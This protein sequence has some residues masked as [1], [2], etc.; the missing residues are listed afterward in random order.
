MDLNK[1]LNR[2]EIPVKYTWD[3]ESLYENQEKWDIDYKILEVE[4][5]GFKKF[6]GKLDDSKLLLEALTSRDNIYRIAGNLYS[7]ASLKLDEDTRASKYQMLSDKAF[8][9]YVGAD[10]AMAFFVPEILSLNL[11]K[12]ENLIKENEKLKLYEKLLKEILRKKDHILSEKEEMIMAKVSEVS[13]NS[14]NVFSML[15]NADLKFPTIKSET[16]EEIEITHGNYVPLMMSTNRDV[17]KNT[18]KA[19]YSVYMGLKNTFAATLD[20]EVKSN[21]FFAEMRGYKTSLVASLDQNNISEAVYVNLID[22]IHGNMEPMYKYISMRKKAMDLDEIHMYDIH[23]PI[24]KDYEFKYEFEDAK[25]LVEKALAPLGEDYINIVKEG[26]N[27]RWID[28]YENVGKRSGGYSGGSYDSKPFIL[29]NYKNSIDSV[30]TLAHEMGHSIHSYLSRENQP[31]VYS[32]YSIFVAE[33]AS[34]VNEVLLINY[35]LKNSKSDSEKIYLLGH[36]IDAFKSTV[37]RQTMFAEFEKII[38]DYVREE[39]G[40]T[41]DYLN[42][43]Y[44]KLNQ[45]YFGPEMVLDEE[46][47]HE[48][49]RIPHFYYNFYVYQY[50]T[51]YSAAVA[52]A[53]KILNKEQGIVEKY[54]NFLSSGSSDYPIDT[55]RKVGIDMESKEPVENAL[56]VF[57]DLVDQMDDLIK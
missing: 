56:K 29:L 42:A 2:E 16:G 12:I 32:N 25:S 24:V 49:S 23:N 20:G 43:E 10:E 33:V 35:L 53:N 48:W 37:Y 41:A 38:N 44:R 39:G 45:L 30:F 5:E 46:I 15:N 40:L 3:V 9:I 52:I 14:E 13:S 51:G 57:S 4:I 8:R 36:F 22:A 34:T 26:F 55:L 11:E 54:I 19:M 50:A 47:D 28:V 21:K 6:K 27:S 7:Y 18:F 31:F 17:R 1:N